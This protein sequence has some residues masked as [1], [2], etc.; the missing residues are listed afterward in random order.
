MPLSQEDIKKATKSLI[1]N[2]RDAFESNKVYTIDQILAQNPEILERN[3][4]RPIAEEVLTEYELLVDSVAADLEKRVG[5]IVAYA[6][7][8][9]NRHLTGVEGAKRS[10]RFF[11]YFGH[12]DNRLFV[13]RG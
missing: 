9:K 6:N 7:M 11:V 13:L 4:L 5:C 12:D 2:M 8:H 3:I 10:Y 1:L